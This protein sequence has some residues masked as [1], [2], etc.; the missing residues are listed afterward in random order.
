MD[1]FRFVGTL[2]EEQDGKCCVAAAA[3]TNFHHDLEF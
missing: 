3:K 2:L 1:L